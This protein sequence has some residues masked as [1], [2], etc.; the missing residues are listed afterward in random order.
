MNLDRMRVSIVLLAAGQSSRMG[1]PLKQL[2]EVSGEPLVCRSARTALSLEP[3]ELVVVTGAGKGAV[4]EALSDLPLRYVFNADYERGQ[5]TSVAAGV[6]ALSHPCD[7]V[8]V[9]P[10]DLPLITVADLQFLCDAYREMESGSIAVPFFEGRRGNPVLFSSSHAVEV[11]MGR[12]NVGCRK[13]IENNPDLVGIV[14]VPNDHFVV[15]MDTPQDFGQVLERLA[16]SQPFPPIAE[17]PC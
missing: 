17:R 15:D 13:L 8:M 16:S 10:V 7:V 12:T 11:A 1:G 2:I 3:E 6:A 4:E 5:P 14:A 9:M